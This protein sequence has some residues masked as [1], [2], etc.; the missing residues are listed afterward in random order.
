MALS[1]VKSEPRRSYKTVF[2]I[3]AVLI[4]AVY[5]WANFHV[6]YSNRLPGK[7]EIMV[8]QNPGMSYSVINLDRIFPDSQDEMQSLLLGVEVLE[9]DPKLR[10]IIDHHKI[11]SRIFHGYGS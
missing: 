4:S 10:A 3:S 8:K 9:K 2:L 11:T 6:F 1:K 5:G 7:L